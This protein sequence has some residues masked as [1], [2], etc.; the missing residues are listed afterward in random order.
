MSRIWAAYRTVFVLGLL[1]LS[2]LISSTASADC[3]NPD[4][5]AGA[6]IYN[7]DQ[8]VPQVCAGSEWVA[9]GV[10]NPAAGGGSCT[11]PSR[12]EG[13]IIYNEDFQVL[14]YCDGDDWIAMIGNIGASPCTSG[15]LSFTTV[16][17]ADGNTW[18]T[19]EEQTITGIS[20]PC[21]LLFAPET[22]GS[23][24]Y[25]SSDTGQKSVAVNAGDK[26]ALRMLS[27]GTGTTTVTGTVGLGEL[28]A[29]W[30]ITTSACI[31]SGSQNYTAVGTASHTVDAGHK[32]CTF[33]VTVKGSGGGNSPG[34][35]GGAGGGVQFNF[36]PNETGTFE[37]LVG[38]I[39]TG[40]GA[41]AASGSSAAGGGG[42]AVRFVGGADT[43]LAVSGGGGGG[44]GSA[45]SGGVGGAGGSANGCGTDGAAGSSNAG[46][47]RGGCSNSGG[48]GGGGGGFEGGGG[49]SGSIG[50][51]N[52][53]NGGGTPAATGYAAFK[54]AGGG[55]AGNYGGGSG[56]GGYGGGGGSGGNGSPG[57]TSHGGGGGGGYVNTG[58]VTN[59]TVVAGAPANTNGSV[60]ISWAP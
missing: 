4:R 46:V 47:G 37:I 25:N 36:S 15:P 29:D 33:T 12:T 22:E 27:A 48:S 32:N 20:G 28:V 9:L 38:G 50:G 10:L 13:A 59:D 43:L 57:D 45:A 41:V 35:S 26:I 42:S 6:I 54:V 8:N 55:K 16:A 52:G 60:N 31:D 34:K 19:S 44:G 58:A 18:Y 30:T 17:D 56:G 49:I 1:A 21:T 3:T 39:G 53:N 7:E 5:A 51:S 24:I 2:L 23:I 14:Q 11:N 40:S